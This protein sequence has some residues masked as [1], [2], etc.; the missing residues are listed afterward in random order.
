MRE[1][2]MPSLLR[3][4][5][6]RA[7][8]LAVAMAFLAVP[9]AAQVSGDEVKI[10][11]LTDLSGIYAD[12]SGPGSVAAAQMAVED[13]GSRAAGKPVVVVSADHQH[14]ADVGA[15]IARRWI[16]TEGVD[17]LTDL[18]NSSVALAVQQLAREKNRIAIFTSPGATDL[19]GKQCS[20]TGI[21]WVYDNYSNAV[22]P[23][24]ALVA[25]GMD[26]WFFVT[27]DFAFGH[28][29]ER[30][31]T[32]A[33]KAA[34]GRVVGTVRHPLGT[35]DLSSFLLQAQGSGAKVIALANAANDTINSIKQ[36]NE[37]GIVGKS[38]AIVAPVLFIT[39]V[40]ALGL[41]AAQ[42]ISFVSG[43]YWDRNDETRA[44]AR[45]F[46]E[47]RGVMPTMSQAGVYSAV[48]HY[49][50]AIDATG[51]DEAKAVIARM[52]A[53]PVDDM[54][55]KGGKVRADGRMVHDMYLVEVKRPEESKGPWDYYKVTA[56]IPGD[57][58]F[59]PLERSECPGAK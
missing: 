53:T 29:L 44:F 8:A 9:V 28:S 7:A 56:T 1:I 6:L 39:D 45:R 19:T 33:V 59:L 49:L 34:G 12:L 50:K 58:A 16:D 32:E 41:K 47:R 52:R 17:M 46:S 18:T 2:S 22:G 14:K 4:N 36:A 21:H 13:H 11:V 25:K 30:V 40:H 20:P 54:F 23:V 5:A 48:R 57:E 42:G 27:V 31:A 55:A 3:R 51:T 10:G 38:Q 15:G 37:F 35:S 26:T 43:F 24:K